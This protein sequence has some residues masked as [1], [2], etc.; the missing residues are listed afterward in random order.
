MKRLGIGLLL[1]GLSAPAYGGS[2]IG[3]EN[4]CGLGAVLGQPTGLS[5][6]C[7]INGRRFGWDALVAWSFI[8][9]I[10]ASMSIPQH[11]GINRVVEKTGK[12][13]LVFWCGALCGIGL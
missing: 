5:G 12:H 11:N 2:D 9:N 4:A 10:S 3:T 7:Y 13:L 1:G 6:K 8:S